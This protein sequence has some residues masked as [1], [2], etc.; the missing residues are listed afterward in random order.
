MLDSA[1]PKAAALIEALSYIQRFH[2]KTIVRENRRLDH[3]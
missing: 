3:G 2:D 1:I